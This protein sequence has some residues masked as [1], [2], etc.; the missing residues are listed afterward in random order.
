MTK[1]TRDGPAKMGSRT[2]LVH[3]G[4]APFENHGFIN[5]P[6]YR[7]S[8]VLYP[9][10]EE[11][12]LRRVKYTYGTHGTPTTDSLESAWTELCGAAGTVLSPS[13][14][15]AISVALLSVAKAGGHLLVTDSAYRPTRNLSNTILK[16]LGVDTTYYDPTVGAGISE[17]IRP[18]TFAVVVEAPGSQS[19]EMQDIPAIA[20]AAHAR[21]VCVIM[22]NTWATPLF[23]PPHERGV[24]IAIEAGTK[25]LSG[26]SDLL[27]GL[28]SAN[29][30]YWPRLKETQDA[31]ANCAGPEDVFLALRGLRTME[32][33]LR[34]AERQGLAMAQWL[35]RRPEVSRVL[36][37]ALPDYPGHDI[38]KRDFLG[39]SGLFSIVLKPASRE[40]VAALLDSLEL[41][42]LGYSW[43]GFESLVIPF[44]CSSY[45]TATKWAPEGPALRFSI[46]LENIEDLQADLDRGFTA[47]KSVS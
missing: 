24:D 7:G 2:R 27:L 16:R 46:G 5:T 23:F 21:D 34:E 9:N 42:G 37:P 40:K 1:T 14:L 13:G 3:A 15:A 38:W 17:L 36:H 43:G 26:H 22:D 33:R 29:E 44:D 28:V 30:K 8:T 6:I 41:F 19:F 35:A 20:A 39:S 32:L 25:Y 47:M 4:R 31:M 10:T 18:N 12:Y 45:R 11:L